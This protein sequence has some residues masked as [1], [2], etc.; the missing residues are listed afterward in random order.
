M[1]V[2]FTNMDE[3]TALALVDWFVGSG[4]QEFADICQIRGMNTTMSDPA[5][6]YTN[7]WVNR[8]E[9]GAAVVVMQTFEP[10]E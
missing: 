2:R 1:D 4:E 3:A 8:D 9:N 7:G 10:E 6:T 5:K